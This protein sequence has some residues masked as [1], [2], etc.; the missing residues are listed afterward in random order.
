VRLSGMADKLAGYQNWLQESSGNLEEL[1]RSPVDGEP[2]ERRR[3]LTF[4]SA[5]STSDSVHVV[6]QSGEQMPG[7]FPEKTVLRH[8]ET[9]NADQ[10]SVSTLIWASFL[11]A[12]MLA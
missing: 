8:V 3:L 1:L 10:L 4:D 7:I 6:S 2:L 9:T 5:S 11:A 12:Y